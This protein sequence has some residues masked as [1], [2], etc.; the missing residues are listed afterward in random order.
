MAMVDMSLLTE[1][2][3]KAWK[4]CSAEIPNSQAPWSSNVFQVKVNAQCHSINSIFSAFVQNLRVVFFG[5]TIDIEEN[6]GIG[7]VISV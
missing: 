4:T 1:T 7:I 5:Q 6:A 2:G 3:E